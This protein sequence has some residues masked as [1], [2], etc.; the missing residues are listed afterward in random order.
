GRWVEL[1]SRF[2]AATAGRGMDVV[3]ASLAGEL[4][5]A[6]LRLL[7][8]GGRFLEM[9]KTDIRDPLAVAA[10]YPGVSYRA[11]DLTEAGAERIGQMLAELTRLFEEGVLTPLPV[12]AWD[13][14]RAP[15]A[16]R[17]LGRARHVGKIVLTIPAAARPEGLADKEGTVLVT[18]G[19]GVLGGAVARHLAARGAGHLLLASRRG[20]DAPGAGELVG[21]LGALGVPV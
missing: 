7:P 1:A 6:S 4:V 3:L 5:D 2:I 14:R 13:V 21:E 8:R 16:V 11:F 17:A 19:T 20:M 9:G 18:G 10:A 15:E 12:T